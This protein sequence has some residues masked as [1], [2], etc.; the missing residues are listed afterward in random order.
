[1]HK[2]II[3]LLGATLVAASLALTGCTEPQ[4]TDLKTLVQEETTNILDVRTPQEFNEGHLEGAIN[5]DIQSPTISQAFDQLPKD[6]TYI[7]YCRSGNRSAQAIEQMKKA[8]FTN[9]I[10]A[11]SIQEASQTTGLPVV[12]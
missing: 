10:D 8:G 11:G 12:N 4:P 1:M 6:R 9:L 3:T 2:K 7:V 5:V